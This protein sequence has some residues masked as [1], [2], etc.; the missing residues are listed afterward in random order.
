MNDVQKKLNEL[1]TKL[2]DSSDI[3]S[4]VIDKKESQIGIICIKSMVDNKLFF[5]NVCKP[6]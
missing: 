2:N 6:I 4:C 1:K 5:D 3:Y